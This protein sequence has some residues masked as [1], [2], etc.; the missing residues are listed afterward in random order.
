MTTIFSSCRRT[1]GLAAVMV[2]GLV[3]A[4]CASPGTDSS[5]RY[6]ENFSPRVTS[7]AVQPHH[8]AKS[9]KSDTCVPDTQTFAEDCGGFVQYDGP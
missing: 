8:M 1:S 2:A 7:D 9:L 6:A 5:V 4:A 3:L